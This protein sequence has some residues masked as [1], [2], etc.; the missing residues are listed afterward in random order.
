MSLLPVT[1]DLNLILTGSLGP[2]QVIVAR[3]IAERLKLPF[4]DAEREVEK[5]AEM[6]P[7]AF[8]T[9][10][11][12]ARLRALESEVIHDLALY[13]GAV[14]QIGGDMLAHGDH[15]SR[16]L[17]CGYII[18]MV[19]SLDAVLTR[20]H[21]ALGARYHDPAERALTLGLL[22]RNW[23]IRGRDPRVLEFDTT[24]LTEQEII[25]RI[26]ALWA[27]KVIEFTRVS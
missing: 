13:R 1:P 12:E 10:F 9:L 14:M 11:G 3:R 20:L 22:R 15:L 16:M 19:A 8:K 6:L 23:S 5:R 2:N 26:A 21:I 27:E 7:E 17:A 25:D 18:C 24:D 4:V